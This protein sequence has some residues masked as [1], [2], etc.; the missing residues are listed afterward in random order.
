MEQGG[1]GRS[2]EEQGGAGWS[3]AEKGREGGSGEGRG[4]EEHGKGRV[5]E[6]RVSESSRV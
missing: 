6:A 3:G 4:G 2:R 5:G 1:A